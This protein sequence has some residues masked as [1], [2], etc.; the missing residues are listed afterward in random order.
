MTMPAPAETRGRLT[1]TPVGW[2]HRLARRRILM[3]VVAVTAFGIAAS[4]LAGLEGLHPGSIGQ[5]TLKTAMGA[6]AIT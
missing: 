4:P 5:V 6:S 3:A 2:A 1:V